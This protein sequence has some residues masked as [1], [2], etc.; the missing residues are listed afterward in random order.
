MTSGNPD[1]F[2]AALDT[3]KKISNEPIIIVITEQSFAPRNAENGILSCDQGCQMVCF[4]TKIPNLGKVWK[5][6]E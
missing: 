5:A 2:R 6:L 4:Q 1:S 3:Q